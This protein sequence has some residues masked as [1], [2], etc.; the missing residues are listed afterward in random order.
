[1][2]LIYFIFSMYLIG[3]N[4]WASTGPTLDKLEGKNQKFKSHANYLSM[5]IDF[6]IAETLRK[7]VENEIGEKLKNRGEAHIT[8]ITPAEFNILKQKMTIE[9]ID[10]IAKVQN[11]QDS[12]LTPICIGMS[13][14]IKDS[15]LE[16]YYVVVESLDLIKIRE[17]IAVLFYARAG[18][19]EDFTPHTYYPHMTLGFNQRDLHLESDGVIKNQESCSYFFKN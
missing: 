6:S 16:T 13:R 1:M 19:N 4:L 15:K 12:R 17:K 8:V 18:S 2:K 14:S 3:I 11:I 7:W 5:R 9:E 10:Q